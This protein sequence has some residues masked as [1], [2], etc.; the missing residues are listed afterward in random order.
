MSSVA[1]VATQAAMTQLN[2][3]VAVV[4]KANEAQ[5]QIVEMI[6]ATVDSNRGQGLNILV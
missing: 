6:A 2:V 1:A 3:A 5:A 4:K